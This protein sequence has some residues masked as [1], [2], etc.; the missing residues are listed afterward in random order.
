MLSQVGWSFLAAC[1]EFDLRWLAGGR[2]I[3]GG[4]KG[5]QRQRSFDSLQQ[6]RPMKVSKIIYDVV[7]SVP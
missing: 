6:I 2:D 7:E 5:S 1:F 4:L 3:L